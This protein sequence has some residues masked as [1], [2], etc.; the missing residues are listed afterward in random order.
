MVRKKFDRG[1]WVRCVTAG[2]LMVV[3]DCLGDNAYCSWLERGELRGA[4][5]ALFSLHAVRAPLVPTG[6]VHSPHLPDLCV[7]P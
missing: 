3:I 5:F 1:Q 6:M 4:K 2:R 7:H